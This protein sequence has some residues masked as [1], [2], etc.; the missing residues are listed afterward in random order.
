MNDL[1]HMKQL[2]QIVES[3]EHLAEA[4]TYPTDTYF[5]TKADLLTV[6]DSNYNIDHNKLMQLTDRQKPII[7]VIKTIEQPVQMPEVSGF[8]MAL[9]KMTLPTPVKK[10]VKPGVYT[11]HQD[12]DGMIDFMGWNA[13]QEH[14]VD[15]LDKN[16]REIDDSEMHPDVEYGSPLWTEYD[17]QILIHLKDLINYIQ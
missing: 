17:R 13:G 8:K 4:P 6:I 7:K 16:G 1:D 11:L 5:V 15:L 2:I 9:R 12:Q 10:V 3:A 14:E